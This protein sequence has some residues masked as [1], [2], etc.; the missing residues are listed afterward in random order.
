MEEIIR[1]N[2]RMWSD[3]IS[4]RAMDDAI[5]HEREIVYDKGENII[6]KSGRK[7]N[8]IADKNYISTKDNKIYDA[9]QAIIWI[10]NTISELK[11]CALYQLIISGKVQATLWVAIFVPSDFLKEARLEDISQQAKHSN[12][13]VFLEDYTDLSNGGNPKK[14]QLGRAR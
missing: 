8:I 5:I 3:T 6:S 1:A 2:L 9:E 13:E 12:I 11:R 4:F 14:Y 7:T 10:N